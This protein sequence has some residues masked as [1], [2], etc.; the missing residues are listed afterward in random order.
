MH[1]ARFGGGFFFFFFLVCLTKKFASK[2]KRAACCEPSRHLVTSPKKSILNMLRFNSNGMVLNY[3]C[4]S[5]RI[6]GRRTIRPGMVAVRRFS[7]PS[8]DENSPY[9][10]SSSPHSSG[11][12]T[13][14]NSSSTTSMHPRSSPLP[15]PILEEL[16]DI[17]RLA[18]PT[19]VERD[20]L[21]LNPARIDPQKRSRILYG[22]LSD[23][24]SMTS[25]ISNERKQPQ[26]SFNLD[27]E[28]SPR[29]FIV[30]IDNIR[31]TLGAT[32]SSQLEMT[33]GSKIM[34]TNRNSQKLRT[35]TGISG[36]VK[37]TSI[38]KLRYGQ[39]EKQLSSSF[40]VAQLREYLKN[41]GIGGG[42]KKTKKQ[43][44]HVIISEGW[45][46][47]KSDKVTDFSDLIESRNFA[48]SAA[49]LFLLVSA[50]AFILKYLSRTG[51][52]ISIDQTENSIRFA[53]T[54]T[55]LQ[56][57]E[58]ILNVMLNRTNRENVDL[59]VIREL[60]LEKFGKFDVRGVS[61]TSEVYF[62][63]RRSEQEQEQEPSEPSEPSEPVPEVSDKSTTS[64]KTSGPVPTASMAD[65]SVYSLVALTK[66][67]LERA[68]RLLLWLLN[69]NTHLKETL[70]TVPSNQPTTHLP[71]MDDSSL[72]WNIRSK[73]LYRV[74]AQTNN[75][76]V[77]KLVAA[78]LE[79]F[80]DENLSS[81]A[82]EALSIEDAKMIPEG[83]RGDLLDL[84]E[85]TW[86]LLQD[87]GISEEDL[88]NEH[89]NDKGT[90]LDISEDGV[91]T[92]SSPAVTVD[93]TTP[94]PPGTVPTT[95]IPSPLLS[96]LHS[97]ITDF[98]YRETLH[99]LPSSSINPP[100]FTTTLGTVLFES[101]DNTDAYHFNSNVPFVADQILSK[102][103]FSGSAASQDSSDPHYYSIQLKFLPSPY[104]GHD[105]T[106][107]PPVEMFVELNDHKK[108][109]LE[110]LS[111]VTV[112]GE[113]NCYVSLPDLKVDLKVSCQV[114]GNILEEEE[115]A[116]TTASTPGP[117]ADDT[118]FLSL[119][120]STS[121]KFSKFKN[122][123]GLDLFFA[124]AKL[125]FSGHSRTYIPPHLDL[126]IDGKTVR[127]QYINMVYRRTLD[128]KVGDRDVQLNVVEGG[129]L[130]G[131]KLEVNLIGDVEGDVGEESL[132]GLLD[133][134]IAIA[135]NL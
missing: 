32:I 54:S 27:D 103:F 132:K 106:K 28:S 127:Y 63:K 70:V 113:N 39:L 87:L 114:S 48:I 12:S 56:N 16:E 5:M 14:S 3:G 11:A 82:V 110:T 44:I 23:R 135:T 67:Q 76:Y 74:R 118:S 85:S 128:M 21:V 116:T 37:T 104:S 62:E 20:I 50:N 8:H 45:K 31:D 47:E 6:P 84:G 40:T 77:N 22:K 2:M 94:T 65:T 125:D 126:C 111:L 51:C 41:K 66:T 49:D 61:E 129:S 79:R 58:L 60:Y 112:E 122:Q 33:K 108:P 30:A 92:T 105:D 36:P 133:D 131:R 97:S 53:G 117:S 59:S 88:R 83:Q 81:E 38:T 43:L 57:A 99:G 96:T 107:Y 115:V 17:S 25:R 7:S 35:G 24:S 98:S 130:G 46:L 69:Y 64:G 4:V 10:A 18:K 19:P 9:S 34:I 93:D 15:S 42:S 109:D 123:P 100:I 80:S 72:P 52:R 120:N 91:T 124:A 68:K 102:G 119:L 75:V 90:K 1:T 121:T 29:D 134:T 89:D 55:Q 73:R 95:T 78:D 26:F 13:S 101:K 86:K 71:Y